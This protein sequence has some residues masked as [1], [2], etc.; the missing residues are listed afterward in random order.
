MQENEGKLK[1]KTATNQSFKKLYLACYDNMH[2]TW[3][4]L[5]ES[6]LFF[7]MVKWQFNPPIDLI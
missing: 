2:F 1:N 5:L 6:H 4:W 7:V 3:I